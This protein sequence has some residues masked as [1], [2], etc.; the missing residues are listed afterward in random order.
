VVWSLPLT[1]G[2]GGPPSISCTAPHLLASVRSWH[3]V[4]GEARVLDSGA[5][6]R[7]GQRE[8]GY[9]E[10]QNVVFEFRT[11]AG[12]YER[13][14]SLAADL[15]SRRVNVICA[16]PTVAALAAKAA[17]TSIPIAF[18]VGGDPVASG[19]VSNLPRPTGNL[20]GIGR[21]N[22]ELVQKRLQLLHELV[23][24]AAP[25]A[26][27]LNPYNPNA[28]AETLAVKVAADAYNHKLLIVRVGAE[29]DFEPAFEALL[30]NQ[31]SA[32]IVSADAYLSSRNYQIVALTV[33]L[34]IPAIFSSRDYPK[35]GGLM[36]YGIN[37]TE[38]DRQQG[39]YA[40]R[41]LRG[42]WPGHEPL[43]ARRQPDR[44]QFLLG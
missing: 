11:A 19:L 43:A 37:T 42:A 33:R 40:G 24:N 22:V 1:A 18:S 38:A 16:S 15:V 26:L 7:Q 27:L 12:Q 30:K 2:S 20:T 25:L 14:A 13:L 34:G 8:M 3:T 36:S 23:P 5:G 35:I 21:L 31:P 9:V 39:V 28:E 6:F 29:G 41:I 4:I 44:R 17:T 32:L 10:D